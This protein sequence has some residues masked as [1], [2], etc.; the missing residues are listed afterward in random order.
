ME[1]QAKPAS[2]RNGYKNGYSDEKEGQPFWADLL[3]SH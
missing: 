2:S 1:Q 3:V